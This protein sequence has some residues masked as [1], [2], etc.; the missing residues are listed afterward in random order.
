M[1]KSVL[2]MATALSV[3]AL[4]PVASAID[5]L[6]LEIGHSSESTTTYRLGAQFDFGR[7]LWQSQSGGVHLGGYW[8]TGVIRWSGLD[9]T[10]FALAPVFVLSF[11]I[12]ASWTPYVEAGIGVSYFTKTDL[13]HDRDLGSKFQ[14]EDRLG[15]G[16]RFASGS[17]V[18]LRVYHYSN[19]GLK[20]PNNGIETTA[21][22]YRYSF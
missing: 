10:T 1:K 9:A 20:N 7:T 21:L 6:T 3:L 15:A 5:G 18:G 11:P 16:V 12:Q 2:V 19:A 8:D 17:E 13:D 14:F 22:H 4:S